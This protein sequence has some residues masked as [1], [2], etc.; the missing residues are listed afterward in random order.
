M[1]ELPHYIDALCSFI[2]QCLHAGHLGKNMPSGFLMDCS[3]MR[4]STCFMHSSQ[5]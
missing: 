1:D 5:K 3:D 2:Y 4:P